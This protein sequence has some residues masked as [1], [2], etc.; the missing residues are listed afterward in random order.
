M[1]AYA[2]GPE[3]KWAT[4]KRKVDTERL[5]KGREHNDPW[6]P[7]QDAELRRL[8]SLY[9]YTY[10]EIAERLKR[11]EGAIKRRIITLDIKERPIRQPA[12]PWTEAEEQELI[13]MRE[14][15]YGWDNIA[16][17]LD[18]TALCVRG[19]YERLLNPTYTKR[20]YR[21][22]REGRTKHERQETC[23]HFI[24]IRGCEMGRETCRYCR[25]YKPLQ[26]GEKQRSDYIG[27][28]EVKPEQIREH[29]AVSALAFNADWQQIGEGAGIEQ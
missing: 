23:S 11:S 21:N 13:R 4:L 17:E 19:K 15:G 3:P 16:A 14:Q 25:H 24:K 28:R 18:R 9:R 2:F 8:L 26:E 29:Q 1:E 22:A 7:A 27:I 20:I 5:R 10:T 6:T 12:R